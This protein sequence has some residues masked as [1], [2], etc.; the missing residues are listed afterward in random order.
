M[1]NAI[2]SV[3]PDLARLSESG[4][5]GGIVVL[6]LSAPLGILGA[7]A[8]QRRSAARREATRQRH[9][10]LMRAAIVG[11]G[12]NAGDEAARLNTRASWRRR[13]TAAGRGRW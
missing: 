7:W 4:A 13:V 10:R 6:A 12:A 8:L 1:P 3:V 9:E 11:A 2:A 5:F